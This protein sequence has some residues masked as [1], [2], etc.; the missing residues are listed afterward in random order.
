MLTAVLILLPLILSVP[1][2]ISS[3]NNSKNLALASSVLSLIVSIA[4]CFMFQ[5]NAEVQFGFELNWVPALGLTLKAG[6][7]GISII[8]VLLT[9][10]LVPF[11]ILSSDSL[12]RK[13]DKPNLFLG[14][15]LLMQSALV[16][17]FTSFDAFL[18]YVFWE[19]ALIPIYLICLMWGG[20]SRIKIT[21]KFFVYTMVGSLLMLI[22][23]VYLYQ[24]TTGEPHS[25][26]LQAMYAAGKALPADKQGLVFWLIF[27]AFA[28]KMPV[29]PF[30]SWQ[31]DTYTDAP[32]QGTMLL[33]GIMLKMGTYG[34][35]RWLIPMVP[36]GVEAWGNTAIILSII[37]IIYAALLAIVQSDYK[38]L[39]AYSSFSHVG[40]I[41]AGIFAMNVQSMQGALYQMLS[42]GINVVALFY[43][44]QLI[45]E[46]TGTRKIA[47]LGGIRGIAPG[48]A[49]VFM[50]VMLGSVAL[51]LTNGF[52]GEFFLIS[53]IYQYNPWYAALAGLTVILGAVYMLRSYQQSMLGEATQ[54]SSFAELTSSEKV[55]LYSM[56]ILIFALGVFP[57]PILNLSEP[58]VTQLLE[59]ARIN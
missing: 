12:L 15:V 16:G 20:E 36:L 48:F 18:F 51:P 22:G 50:I 35:I 33:S 24:H 6:I 58:A 47:E 10:L 11:I 53:G 40:L 42:H 38:R 2:F 59:Q 8:P 45:E 21:L 43:I 5:K 29:F 57:Q 7:D 55:I 28:I 14:L 23:L 37:G 31:P 41:A 26:D 9:N 17:V 27:M 44:I 46:R 13:I 1:L 19:L 52:V 25:F 3:S 54:I 4:V 56:V 34:L 49:T 39:I 30:H 32:A